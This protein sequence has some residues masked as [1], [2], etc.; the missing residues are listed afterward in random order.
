QQISNDCVAAI[1]SFKSAAAINKTAWGAEARYELAACQF[2]QNNLT[3]A[4]KSAM[5]VIKETGSYDRWVTKSYILMGDIFMKQKDYFNAKATFESVAKNAAIAE[6]KSEAQQK[7]DSAVA[8][9]KQ[10]S[11]IGN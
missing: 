7:Y 2:S 4:E 8:E 1:A 10:H 6:L 9:E 3:A 11:K 5:A